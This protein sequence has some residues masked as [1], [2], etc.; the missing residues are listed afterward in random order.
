MPPLPQSMSSSCSLDSTDCF[1][2]EDY[3][4]FHY[5]P[6]HKRKRVRINGKPQLC[7]YIEHVS[8]LTQEER[9]LRWY[10]KDEFEETKKKAKSRCRELR[11]KGSFKRC[12]V[13]AYDQACNTANK[14][15]HRIEDADSKS[16][17]TVIDPGTDLVEWCTDVQ[18]GLERW[19]SKV[20]GFLRGKH[21]GEAKHAVLLE[22]ARQF[23][24]NERD[25]KKMAKV[26]THAS[27]S[28]RLFAQLVAQADATVVFTEAGKRRLDC[29]EDQPRK[30]VLK[31]EHPQQ[32]SDDESASDNEL[33]SPIIF[34]LAFSNN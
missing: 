18:R 15:D 23:L 9:S 22:Q 24:V 27:R 7:G 12:L 29:V 21:A 11:R 34:D 17:S 14:P 19:T 3:E 26:A 30:K 5:I 1:L 33:L 13:N 25:E 2:Q 4:I 28:A 32:N 6:Q 20:H 16:S 8:D 31:V 10:S